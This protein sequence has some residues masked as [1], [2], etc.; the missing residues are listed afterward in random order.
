MTLEPDIQQWSSGLLVGQARQDMGP[1]KSGEEWFWGAGQS[2][3]EAESH[4]HIGLGLCS[5]QQ[6]C[7][8]NL[9]ETV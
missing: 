5:P 4:A 3:E 1:T 7:Q 9:A 6:S 8:A 2:P